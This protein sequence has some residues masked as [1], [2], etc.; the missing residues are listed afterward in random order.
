MEE[1][2]LIK[3]ALAARKRAYAP[4]SRFFVGA[5][6][7]TEGGKVFTGCNIEN[8]AYT[9]TCCAER[10]AFCKAVGE[11]ERD[12][13]AMAVVGGAED[14]GRLAFC[15][16]CGVCRQFMREFCGDDFKIVLYEGTADGADGGTEVHTLKELLP[17]SF[18]GELLSAK[19]G[20]N[21]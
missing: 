10:T 13:S 9:P 7:L 18:G 3:A 6:L 19:G 21:P 2:E 8:S 4:Y 16:P 15:P 1:K 17:F 11:G 12:F 5:A 20:K 14:S